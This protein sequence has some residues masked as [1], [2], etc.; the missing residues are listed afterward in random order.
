MQFPGRME[1][2]IFSEWSWKRHHSPEFS[3]NQ[4]ILCGPTPGLLPVCQSVCIYCQLIFVRQ[5]NNTVI[6]IDMAAARHA[7]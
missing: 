7:V 1:R 5:S 6:A 2:S 4:R 3:D